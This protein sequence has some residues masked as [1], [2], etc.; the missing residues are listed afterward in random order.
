MEKYY[1]TFGSW[2]KFPYQN[3]YLMVVASSYGDAVR[4]FREKHPD[5]NPG[6][7]NCSDCYSQK[8]WDDVGYHYS[9]K[10]PAEVIWT[11]TCF[12]KKP[13]GYDD[14][15]IFVPEMKQIVRIAEGTGDN[16]LPEDQDQGYVDY[17]YYE[18]Y[19]LSHDVPEVDGG[20]IMLEEMLRDKYKCIADCIQ[21]VLS[22][23]YGSYMVDCMILV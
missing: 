22:M 20:Q 8:Q 2:E 7:M 14:L 23:A 13:E 18:Q 19:E 4:G 15:F 9:G 16:L 3:T 5:I 1:F 10:R 11:E 21:D 17:I 6:C 12:G